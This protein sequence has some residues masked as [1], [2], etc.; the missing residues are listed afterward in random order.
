MP[1]SRLEAEPPIEHPGDDRK[2][3]PF[4][5]NGIVRVQTVE[6]LEYLVV[7]FCGNANTVVMHP[8]DNL[9]IL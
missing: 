1:R 6:Y 4:A 3:K 8:I 2:A 5:G 9:V 7:V